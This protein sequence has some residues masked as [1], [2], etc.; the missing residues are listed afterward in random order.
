MSAI[1]ELK[2]QVI[3]NRLI[4]VV[5]ELAQTL[6]RTAF[7]PSTREAGDLSAGV[8]DIEGR[9]I[10]QAVTGT[11]GH[12]NTM[13][14]AVRHFLKPIPL[15]TMSPGDVY[16][17]NDPW[18]AS[19][20]L[21]DFTVVAPAFHKHKPVGLFAAT[22]HVSDVGG[23]GVGIEAKD[24]H[25]EGLYVPIVRMMRAGTF[26]PMLEALVRSNVRDPVA[27][28]GDLNALAVSTMAGCM[29]LTR[30]FDEMGL[31]DLIELSERIRRKSLEAMK[32][33]ISPL[34]KGVF[35][36]S[37]TIDG[38]EAPLQLTACMTIEE[39]RIL[40]DWSGTS[41]RSQFGINVPLCYT[42]AYTTYGIRCIVGS[43]VPNNEGSLSAITVTAPE[44]CLL[45]APYPA[46]VAARSMIGLMLPDVIMGCLAQVTPKA[47]Q[48]ESS[49][50]L[51]NLRLSGGR[52]TP[53]IPVGEDVNGPRFHITTFNAGGVGA[54]S[55]KDG[56]AATAFPSGVRNVPLEVIES[57]S[58]LVFWRKE[59]RRDSGG[60][61]R[62]RGGDGQTMEVGHVDEEP[63][64]LN[65][66]FDRVENPARGFLGGNAG[67]P[68][69]GYLSDGTP[70]RPEGRQL[71]PAGRRLVI[72]TPGGGGFEPARERD[73]PRI[74]LDIAQ[75]RIS[76]DEAAR[77]YRLGSV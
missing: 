32:A 2:Q 15:E 53:G 26:D 56:L 71:F 62:Y 61:G 22:V 68:G 43:R 39:D 8:F 7:S 40:V 52:G 77:I 28:L 57:I 59:L 16:V 54:R 42:A 29:A 1:D 65:A 17:T 19:G 46:P 30:M 51:W 6:V 31:E 11:P 34:P 74:E 76:Q 69:R 24:V 27:V 4:S 70:L 73:R 37:M 44:D 45:N 50:V 10:A 33:A 5:N 36:N 75:E 20:H 63:F 25:Q 41:Q 23:L 38:V 55:S 9:M 64:V 48:T 49:S 47:V 66:T 14:Q 58:P 3:W 67:A 35:S 13:A 72:D 18:L 60:A 21:N 12:V